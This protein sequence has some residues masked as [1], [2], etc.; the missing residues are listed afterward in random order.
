MD[1]FFKWGGWLLWAGFLLFLC[2]LAFDGDQTP[3][4]R[5]VAAAVVLALLIREEFQR[6]SK[7]IKALSN[8]LDKIFERTEKQESYHFLGNDE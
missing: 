8:K 5:A 1:A 3:G 4:N 7:E 6:Q 2:A